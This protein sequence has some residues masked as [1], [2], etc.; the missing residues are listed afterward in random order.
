MS[1][2]PTANI[3]ALA[4]YLEQHGF[5]GNIPINEGAKNWRAIKKLIDK[6]EFYTFGIAEI[7]HE[8][9]TKSITANSVRDIIIQASGLDLKRFSFKGAGY[10]DS[11]KSAA[12]LVEAL[13]RIKTAAAKQQ[14]LIFATGHPGA[15]LGFL[16]ELAAWAHRQGASLVAINEAIHIKDQYYLDMAGPIFT[17]SDGCSAWH[18]HDTAYMEKLLDRHSADLVVGDHGFVGAALNHNLPCIG[19][20]DTDDPAMPLAQSLGLPVF[21]VPINDNRHNADSAAL[22]RFLIAHHG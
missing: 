18:S 2:K 5:S 3:K 4:E 7:K 13:D 19:F 16:A 1:D 22:A 10:F 14:R 17:P 8:I 12:T 21:A 6:E 20:Y 15:M 9:K 11:A